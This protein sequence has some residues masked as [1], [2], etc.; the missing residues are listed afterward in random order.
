MPTI[1]TCDKKI[2]EY[3]AELEIY[4]AKQADE[5]DDGDYMKEIK[6]LKKKIASWESKKLVAETV[7]EKTEKPTETDTTTALLLEDVER[8]LEKIGTT[9]VEKKSNESENRSDIIKK[10]RLLEMANGWPAREDL[11]TISL[12]DLK[13]Y[14]SAAAVS[15]KQNMTSAT[16]LVANLYK[17]LLCSSP[18][19]INMLI[20]DWGICID[21]DSLMK[22]LSDPTTLKALESAFQEIFDEDPYL[23]QIAMNISRGLPKL[24]MLTVSLFATSLRSLE[25]SSGA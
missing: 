14:H 8:E 5:N 10:V 3:T 24:G 11:E 16:G 23:K 6:S 15:V 17:S 21:R 1:A 19:L 7:K 4:E 25:T 13:S 18:G 20:A 9:V 2:A 12:E 22:S